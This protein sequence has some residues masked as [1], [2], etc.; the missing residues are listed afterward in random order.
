MSRVL[1]RPKL[2]DG[3]FFCGIA[4][5]LFALLRL[6][7]QSVA[8]AR[9]GIGLCLNVILPSLFPFSCSPHCAWSLG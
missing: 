6:P 4:L 9:D 2:R 8:A 3:L 5:M 7:A 1:S